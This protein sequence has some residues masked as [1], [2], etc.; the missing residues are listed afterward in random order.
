MTFIQLAAPAQ[1]AP[2]PFLEINGDVPHPRIFQEQEWKQLKHVSLTATN[3]HDKKTATYS[4]VPLR[5]LL[6]EVGLP[7]GENLR[8]KAFA[9]AVV[10]SASDGYQ[11][12]FSI[13][14]L[15]ESVG[16]LQVLVADNENGKPLAQGVGPLRL[17]VV[18]D[19]RPARWVRMVRTIRIV[20]N[21]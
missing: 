11:V 18:S 10:V 13:A 19:K 17:V 9:T 8:G 7:L 14:E 5:D 12:T 1:Q 6:M 21:P 2:S 4:G 3:T 20:T 16:N 15:D